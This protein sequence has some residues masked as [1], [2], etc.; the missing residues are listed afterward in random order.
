MRQH[1]QRQAPVQSVSASMRKANMTEVSAES[2]DISSSRKPL[3]T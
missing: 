1:I 3:P 2:C